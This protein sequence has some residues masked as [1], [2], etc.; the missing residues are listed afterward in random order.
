MILWQNF[1]SRREESRVLSNCVP[2]GSEENRGA[3]LG[4]SVE[5]KKKKYTFCKSGGWSR[6]WRRTY[7]LYVTVKFTG[8][9][10]L[11]TQ[12]CWIILAD[13]YTLP[14]KWK[15]KRQDEEACGDFSSISVPLFYPNDLWKTFI[16][17]EEI[18]ES[19]DI[20]PRRQNVFLEDSLCAPIVP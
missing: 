18:P 20:F 14:I 10:L 13:S 16:P 7:A 9:R 4:S 5:V 1:N 2:R 3:L 19:W 12:L 8:A 15:M 6:A 17:V 11:S